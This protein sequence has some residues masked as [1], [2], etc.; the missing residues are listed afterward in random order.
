MMNDISQK[1]FFNRKFILIGLAFVLLFLVVAK[2][3]NFFVE[4]TTYYYPYSKLTWE[5]DYTQS[6]MRFISPQLLAYQISSIFLLLPGIVFLSMGLSGSRGLNLN[7]YFRKV[8]EKTNITA[9]VIIIAIVVAVIIYLLASF[10]FSYTPITDDEGAYL[11][12]SQIFSEGKLYYPLPPSPENFANKFI[13][14][15]DGKWCSKYPFGYPLVL[16]IGTILS[17]PYIV[18]IF[19][20]AL[21][22][23]LISLVIKN[24][25]GEEQ[26]FRFV[27]FP[28][29]LFFLLSPFFLLTSSTLLAHSFN[30]FLLLVFIL[31]IIKTYNSNNLIYPF[32]AGLTIGWAFNVR[33]LTAIA[34]GFPV[35]IFVVY[36]L[37]RNFKGWL[38]KIFVMGVPFLVFIIAYFYYSRAITG[39]FLLAPFNFYD[40]TEKLGFTKVLSIGYQHTPLLGLTNLFTSLLKINIYMLGWSLPLLFVFYFLIFGKKNK[41]ERLL[42][43][44]TVSH[45][46]FYLFYYS[47]GVSD[48]GPVYYYELLFPLVLFTVRGI[49]LLQRQ[50]SKVSIKENYLSNLLPMFVILSIIFNL[51]IFLPQRLIH[52]SNL[53]YTTNIPYQK[54][55]Q[56]NVHNAIVFID[57]LY[58][59]GWRLGYK[60][61]SPDLEDDIIYVKDRGEQINQKLMDYFEGNRLQYRITFDYEKRKYVIENINNEK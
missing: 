49:N 35:F 55:H 39:S 1:Q 59:S 31:C 8:S 34:W 42:V 45:F 9:F 28:I 5:D 3:F 48:T 24:I 44:I 38:L 56:R 14:L 13:I 11:F 4:T 20:G 23:L 15:K 50:M 61:C 25:Y 7:N 21:S 32:L 58:Y 47:P 33:Q 36:M 60:Y 27:L 6:R 51:L 16:A 22:I 40:P 19:F 53:T 26:N 30:L 10:I 46:F 54:M 12:Q 43:Y 41:W 17:F 29:L 57:K 37:I 2:E 18:P 52:I